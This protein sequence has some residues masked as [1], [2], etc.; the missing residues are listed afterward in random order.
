MLSCKALLFWH[1]YTGYLHSGRVNGGMNMWQD[2]IVQDV[3][4]AGEE[5][6]KQADYSLHKFFQNLRNNEKKRK[7]DLKDM[8]VPRNNE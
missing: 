4:K 1:P 3:R 6:A 7:P 8:R 2:P 5:L